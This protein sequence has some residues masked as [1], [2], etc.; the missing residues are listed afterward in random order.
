MKFD[1]AARESSAE[2]VERLLTGLP[3]WFEIPEAVHQ[4]VADAASLPALVAFDQAGEP[5]GVLVHRRHFLESVEIHVMAVA[6]S[7]HRQGVGR[8]LVDALV[9]L[10][11]A[12]GAQLVSVKTLG[13]SHPDEGYSNTRRF[14]RACGFL[15]VEELHE[16]WGKDNPCLLMVKPLL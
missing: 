9:G 10:A 7:W 5:V 15:P 6:R 13:P 8:A 12:D 16:L 3:E 1:V 4:Y 14:Y 11:A 2:I